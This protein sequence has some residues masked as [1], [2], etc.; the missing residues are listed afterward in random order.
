M[1][2][3]S[4]H[5]KPPARTLVAA[6]RRSLLA[7]DAG[8]QRL[9]GMPPSA[10]A[11]APAPESDAAQAPAHGPAR[12]A[13]LQRTTEFLE[14]AQA[15]GGFGV[16]DLDFFTRRITGTKLFFELI[17]IPSSDL[18][19][20]QEQWLATIHPEDLESFVEHFTAAVAAEGNYQVEYRT[21]LADGRVIW[22][23]GR[24]RVL[25]EKEGY[26]RRLIG[27]VT[28]ITE[29]K[30]LEEKLRDA[31][32]SFSIAQAAAGVA[33][34]DLNLAED[35][36]VAS[37]NFRELLRVPR[38][39]ALSDL[40]GILVSVHPDDFERTRAAP[41]ETTRA[42]PAYRMEYR[43]MQPDGGVRWIGEKAH[44]SHDSQG[45]L[46]RITGA[47]VDI[48]DLKR[49]EA[50]L[51]S[52]EKRLERAVRG[53][54]D[55][56]WEID[57]S[58]HR[59]WFSSRF[60]A[61]LGYTEGELAA[62]GT[63]FGDLIHPEDLALYT[64][65]YS[66]HLERHIPYDLEFRI[67]H[68]SGRYEWV[69]SRAQAECDAAGTPIWLAGSL[70]LVTD[71]KLA[72]QATLEAKRAAEA[73]NHA[74]S[75]FLANMSHEIRTPMNGVIGMSQI[76]SET[77]LDDTQRE[78]V[79]IISGSAQALL[80]LINDVL[81][82]SKIEANRMELEEVEFNLRD[83]I[84]ETVAANA[85]Q[86]TVRG[87]EL[88][89]DI[90]PEVQHLV[91]GDPGRLRQIIVNL[92]GNAIKFT[93]EGHVVLKVQTTPGGGADTLLLIEVTDT[94]IG[95]P[96]DRIDRLFQ[97][98]SQIDS[99]TTR[100]Y[101]GT[102][103]GLAI[104]KRLAELMGGGVGVRS[105]PGRGSTF[106]VTVRVEPAEVQPVVERLGTGKRILIVDDT[107]ASRESLRHKLGLFGFES[108]EVDSVA[109]ALAVLE[110][111][112]RF[113]LV[114]ADEHMPGRGGLALLPAMRSDPRTAAIKFLL[115]TLFGS[116]EPPFEPM[117]HPDGIAKKPIRGTALAR[118]ILKVLGGETQ[119]PLLIQTAPVLTVTFSGKHIL[120]VEDNPVNQRVAQRLLEKLGTTVV[121][122]GNGAEALHRLAL[123][124][125]D[126]VLMDCQMPVMDGFTATRRIR[127]TEQRLGGERHLPIIALTA[128]VMSEDRERCVAAGMDAYLSKPIDSAQLVACLRRYLDRETAMPTV[129]LNALHQLTEGDVEFERELIAT[130]IESGDKNLADIVDA[131]RS[132]DFETIGRRAHALKSASANIHAA[133][134]SSVA[135]HLETATR[136]N[137][138]EEIDGLVQQLS[139]TLQRVN[140]ELRKAG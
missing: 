44:C 99:S 65:A 13:E 57:L 42:H 94:G 109:A 26:A 106:W 79:N 59:P 41:F 33:T 60:E 72:E 126:A 30:R 104:V 87:I 83:V 95:I 25:I 3:W 108:V 5:I 35:H 8:L 130:F 55:G 11:P 48:T 68:R 39:T 2:D 138:L 67:R 28:D 21:L 56:L 103:L 22:L 78:Y 9:G 63:D 98:F 128:N 92:T 131:L 52:T 14:F 7:V 16:F 47:L 61:L 84:Y 97:S 20:T 46:T 105:A 119:S 45:K 116:E 62:E 4:N 110:A 114:L 81:D 122:V 86:A 34:F 80:S 43:V 139:A 23:A 49:T 91:R 38:A 69:R 70:Q 36:C 134:L 132:G 85:L 12:E 53:T 121:V 32:Q 17:G 127:E 37:D 118:L 64:R 27:T 66:D 40:D 117:M 124:H 136:T 54:Q 96:A 129:D 50:A 135:A 112:P 73:A 120:V 89:V 107:A 19:L 90:T 74:K 29:R 93:H 10:A 1:Q 77:T 18:A 6:L 140:E 125:F 76:L 133:A 75:Q 123:G 51:D 58:T 88:I 82:I 31:S 100:H 24:G 115:M 137:S 111:D 113:D 15:A 101:G 71:R 102:G